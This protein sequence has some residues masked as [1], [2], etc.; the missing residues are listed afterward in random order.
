MS[1]AHERLL[2]EMVHA[3]GAIAPPHRP[4]IAT[5]ADGTLWEGDIGDD[6]FVEALSHHPVGS[7]SRACATA[8]GRSSATVARATSVSSPS[9]SSPRTARAR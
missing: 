8:R 1:A 6:L 3:A 4:V 2:R 5:D 7:R 9:R